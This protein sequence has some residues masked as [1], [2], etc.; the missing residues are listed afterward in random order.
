MASE[1][2]VHFMFRRKVCHVTSYI[3]GSLSFEL[4]HCSSKAGTYQP[5]AGVDTSKFN[6]VN[7]ALGGFVPSALMPS[8]L[9][10]QPLSTYPSCMI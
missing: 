4:A 1:Y 10:H 8:E 7:H 2:H 3:L 6:K 9:D 5:P